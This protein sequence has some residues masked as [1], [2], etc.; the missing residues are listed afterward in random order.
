MRDLRLTL[1]KVV[2][3]ARCSMKLYV[4]L[5]HAPCC[6]PNITFITGVTLICVGFMYKTGAG[7][8]A[9]RIVCAFAAIAAFVIDLT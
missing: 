1:I 4:I 2:I 6:F 3:G 8:G 9:G 5:Y 7:F